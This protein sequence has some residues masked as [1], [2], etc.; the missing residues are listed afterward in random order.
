MA[1]PIIV[2]V[3]PLAAANTQAVVANNTP[4]AAGL[5]A[6]VSSTVTLDT[7]RQ[8]LVTFG[9]ETVAR[10]VQ[11]SGTNSFG[12]AFSE[13][14]SVAAGAAGTIS[15]VNPFSTVTAVRVFAAWTTTMSVGTSAVATSEWQIV[16]IVRDPTQIRFRFN[17][18]SATAT[19]NYSLELTM[20]DPNNQIN[21]S[22]VTVLDRYVPL[23]TKFNNPVVPYDDS[24]VSQKTVGMSYI[25]DAP[26][27]A[28]R[29]KV[30]SGA[31]GSDS[32]Q[33]ESIQAGYRGA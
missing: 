1:N 16:D 23:N 27:F 18:S 20:D 9:N 3:G 19:V 32:I 12:C 26:C 5:L 15:T 25:L 33:A 29:L 30:N 10:T 4:A 24:T 31:T 11:I 28:W 21:A 7:L 14:V 6:L 17:L 8:V 2:S 13:T 22:P